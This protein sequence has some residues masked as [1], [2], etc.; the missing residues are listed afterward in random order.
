[1]SSHGCFLVLHP[2]MYL[3]VDG[4]CVDSIQQCISEFVWTSRECY[5]LHSIY[6]YNAR[7]VTTC[8]LSY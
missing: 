1:M 6:I 2:A 4:P 8:I 3:M 5:T 7:Y